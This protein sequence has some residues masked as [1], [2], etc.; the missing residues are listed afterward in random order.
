[1][2]QQQAYLDVADNTGAQQ[3]MCICVL[4]GRRV[5][6]LG[7]TIVAIV[8]ESLPSILIR[9]SEVVCAVVVRTRYNEKWD[10][11][12]RVRFIENA[13]VV[14]NKDGNPRGSR[15]FGPISRELR[16]KSFTK[17]VSLAPEVT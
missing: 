5:A 12:S 2:I 9:R 6:R 1:M 10:K 14:I 16:E 4:G 11:G 7:D 15:I 13:A 8:K 17:V 3:L